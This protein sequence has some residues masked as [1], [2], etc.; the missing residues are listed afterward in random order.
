M[1]GDIVDQNYVDLAVKFGE[2]KTLAKN[3]EILGQPN[4][5]LDEVSKNQQ[6]SWKCTLFTTGKLWNFAK[7]LKNLSQIWVYLPCKFNIILISYLL[8]TKTQIDIKVFL[9]YVAEDW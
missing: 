5:E 3:S 9:S 2:K 8:T 7:N 4:L 6:K 1:A